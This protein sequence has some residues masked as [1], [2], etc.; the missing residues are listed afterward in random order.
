MSENIGSI[1]NTQI[2]AYE[3]SAD[4]KAALKLYH[5]GQT[6][7]PATV[8]DV[9]AESIAGYLIDLQ[10]QI[11]TISSNSGIQ[12]T[13]V[14]AKGDLIVATGA[15]T[16]VRKAVGS[17]NQVLTADSAETTGIKWTAATDLISAA[18]TCTSG[19]V[20]LEDSTSSTST[21]KAATPNSVKTVNDSLGTLSGTVSTISTNLGTLSTTVS[22]IYTD[23]GNLTVN[24]NPQV[25]TTDYTL[26]N[27][28]SG[29]TIIMNV[30][31]GTAVI[32]IPTEAS[33]D[34]YDNSKIDIVQV[35]SIQ[36]SFVAASG[37][38]INSK[39]GNKKIASRYSGATLL[40]L[41][42]DNW[43]LIGDLI[44]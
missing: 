5:Y 22:G 36:V 41:S 37:V 26:T 4:I 3:D 25:K 44:A 38:T 10:D 8:G 9:P 6:S 12:T 30:S 18:S 2:P 31:S 20:Q 43:L 1:Y 34:F 32:T 42:S 27:S 24:I 33:A 16:V 28:D 21:T 11:D 29:K 7:Q 15:D 40:K 17:N 19:K 14:D 35:G 39:N 23:L 13:I